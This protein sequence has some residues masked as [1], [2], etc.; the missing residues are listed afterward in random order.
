MKL[1]QVSLR[2]VF[3]LVLAIQP[4]IDG[5]V[6]STNGGGYTRIPE[7]VKPGDTFE[8]VREGNITGY[9]V[10]DIMKRYQNGKCFVRFGDDGDFEELPVKR[11]K[12]D[13]RKMK[14]ISEVPGERTRD[15]NSV[16]VY[17]T[18]DLDGHANGGKQEARK[19]EVKP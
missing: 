12:V 10:G 17:W 2:D 8:V 4:A 6:Q 9:P 3:W 1:P 15:V 14:M 18:L 7:R 5:C 11:E 19:I 16:W 13:Q